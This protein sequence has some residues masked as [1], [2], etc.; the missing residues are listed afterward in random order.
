L[1]HGPERTIEYGQWFTRDNVIGSQVDALTATSRSSN[2]K[3]LAF[4]AQG[5][6]AL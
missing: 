6:A 5:E 4:N 2:A 3:S 1:E